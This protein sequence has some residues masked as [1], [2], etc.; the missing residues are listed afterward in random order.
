MWPYPSGRDYGLVMLR[1]V[2]FSLHSPLSIRDV[3]Q[4]YGKGVSTRKKLPLQLAGWALVWTAQ[5]GR[6]SLWWGE[7]SGTLQALPGWPVLMP[8]MLCF[9]PCRCRGTRS[10]AAPSSATCMARL[11]A[12]ISA[13]TACPSPTTST[14]TTSAPWTPASSPWWPSVWAAAPSSSFPS[15]RWAPQGELAFQSPSGGWRRDIF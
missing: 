13:T 2:T 3:Q 1:A 8:W 7:G 9:S 5:V 11:P 14:T 4:G 6:V 15:S 10:T 12:R